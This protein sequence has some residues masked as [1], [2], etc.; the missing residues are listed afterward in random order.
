MLKKLQVSTMVGYPIN[1]DVPTNAVKLNSKE[2]FLQKGVT[3]K[4][5]KIWIQVA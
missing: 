2:F 3:H 1:A 5:I 4:P